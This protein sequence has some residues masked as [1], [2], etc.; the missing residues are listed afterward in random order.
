M[1]PIIIKRTNVHLEPGSGPLDSSA[2]AA[3][4]QVGACAQRP[5]QTARLLE[6]EGVVH[7]IELSCA[8]GRT[9]VV[10]L[11]YPDSTPGP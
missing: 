5:E 7:A 6:R 2:A 3:G 1:Q 11:D 10:E 9:T 8:C 4:G